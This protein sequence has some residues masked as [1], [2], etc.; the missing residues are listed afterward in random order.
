MS[1]IY[2]NAKDLDGV[3]NMKQKYTI[4]Q[5][6]ALSKTCVQCCEPLNTENTGRYHQ[7]PK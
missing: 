1:E 5:F 7:G 4:A 2:S 3:G 6:S